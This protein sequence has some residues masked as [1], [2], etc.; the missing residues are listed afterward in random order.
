MSV[1]KATPTLIDITSTGLKVRRQR[2]CSLLTQQELA[3][4]AGVPR[5]H[6]DLLERNL[7]VPLDSKRRI[8]KEIWA[9]KVRK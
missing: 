2:I 6:V 9:I 3:E 8:L 5:K 7:P 4:L 1:M